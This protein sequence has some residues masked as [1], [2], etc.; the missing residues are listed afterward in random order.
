MKRWSIW[1]VV[2]ERKAMK[3]WC[4]FNHQ[5]G[6]NGKILI[7]ASASKNLGEINNIR[8]IRNNLVIFIIPCDPVILLLESIP[9]KIKTGYTYKNAHYSLLCMDKNQNSKLEWLSK[10]SCTH[11]MEYFITIKMNIFPNFIYIYLS[12]WVVEWKKVEGYK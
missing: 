1:Q 12:P 4:C 6:K 11:S 7:V 9:I 8:I 5:S 3:M 10:L 2:T